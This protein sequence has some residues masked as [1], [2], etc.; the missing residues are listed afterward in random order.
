MTR[1]HKQAVA[2]QNLRPLPELVRA[3]LENS[4]S[5]YFSNFP[6]DSKYGKLWRIFE[7]CG[8]IKDV[9]LPLKRN[10]E[11]KRFGFVR[12]E[13]ED[14]GKELLAK[15]LKIR[16]QSFQLNV[17][18]SKFH[19]EVEVMQ[20]V[21]KQHH[22]RASPL[23]RSCLKVVEEVSFASVVVAD[24]GAGTSSIVK[25]VAEVVCESSPGRMEVLLDSV[26]GL[27][28]PSLSI[29][30]IREQLMVSGVP[31]ISVVPLGGNQALISSPIKGL[32]KE[33]LLVRK[34]WWLSWF[35]GFTKWSLEVPRPS[36]CVWLRVAGAPA[37]LWCVNTF[38]KV[39][40]V[41]GE[42]QEVVVD[43]MS[44]EAAWVN[45]L[46]PGL[47]PVSEAVVLVADGRR[48]SVFVS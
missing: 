25:A 17:N 22:V 12:F 34:D 24:K 8:K 31:N 20:P 21:E 37:H 2:H 11:G 42:V 4:I 32:I 7:K 29:Q 35:V 48:Y 14:N 10:K 44:L 30:R 9:F 26:V 6:D 33:S 3:R 19:R 39:G 38:E 40:A 36:R 41:F 47:S 15:L 27:L 13:D 16:V 18:I 5:F 28:R 46:L 45:V 43:E 1:K 23:E